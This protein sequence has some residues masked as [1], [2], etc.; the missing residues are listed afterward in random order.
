[1]Q[2]VAKMNELDLMGVHG[3]ELA[4]AF[5]AGC[6]ACWAFLRTL[7][8]SPL[9]QRVRELEISLASERSMCREMENRLVRR[10]E[11]LETRMFFA[12]L[13]S[14]AISGATE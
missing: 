8:T 4:I 9:R 6:A 11:Q 1:M 7:F 3:G 2:R 5:A 13:A 12:P 10:I 14:S